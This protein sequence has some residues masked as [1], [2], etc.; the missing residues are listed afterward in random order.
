MRNKSPRITRI[1][2][3]GQQA[4]VDLYG[5]PPATLPG[6]TLWQRKRQY[7]TDFVS[8]ALVRG[9]EI[10]FLTFSSSERGRQSIL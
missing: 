9:Y 7:L 10:G 5:R 1:H 3:N 6:I 4:A 8:F 2:T